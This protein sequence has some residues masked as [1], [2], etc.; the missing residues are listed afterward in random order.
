MTNDPDEHAPPNRRAALIALAVV[1]ALL[2]G[3]VA[4]QRYLRGTG[5]IEDCMMS[6]RTNCSPINAD[7]K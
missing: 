2:V 5:Q 6:G 3:G 1:A 4:L 7:S